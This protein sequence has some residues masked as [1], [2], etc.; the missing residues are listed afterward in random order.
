M[1][2]EEAWR[3]HLYLQTRLKE[4]NGRIRLLTV[5]P[6][7]YAQSRPE[8]P[9]DTVH[10]FL[11]L[12]ELKEHPA[13]TVVSHRW[14]ATDAIDDTK[15]VLVNGAR[16]PVSTG[17]FDV[18]YHV[19]K[20]TEPVVVWIDALCI[21]H[22]DEHE[23]E[24]SVQI[25]QLAQIYAAAEKTLI[26]LGTTADRSDEAMKA[27]RRLSEEQLT[28][29]AYVANWTPQLAHQLAEKILPA[30][31]VSP[32]PTAPTP[33]SKEPVELQKELESLRAPLK[34]LMERDYWT[35]LWSLVELCLSHRGIV[36]CGSH[37]L[38]LDHF[39]SAARALDHIINHFTYSRWLAA[40][41]EPAENTAGP[42]SP[43]LSGQEISNLSQSPALRILGRRAEHRRETGSWIKTTETP[44]FALLNRY[45]YY[46]AGDDRKKEKNKE[47][48]K[49]KQQQQLALRVRDA[50]DRVYALSCLATDTKDL[51]IAVDYSKGVDQ[52]N[53]EASA[54]FLH[55]YPRV[56]Q[57][58]QGTTTNLA[59]AA[60]DDTFTTASWAIDW[61]N[62][63]VPPSDMGAAEQ[64]PFNACGPADIRYYRA[65]V[66]LGMPGRIALKTAVVDE[67]EEVGARYDE[68][69]VDGDGEGDDAKAQERQR[70]SQ[71][72]YLAEIKRF[73]EES[74]ASI[75]SPYFAEQAAVALAKIPVGDVE[76]SEASHALARASSAT[77]ERYR[78]MLEVLFPPAEASEVDE[79]VQANASSSS[80]ETGS[81][82][83]KPASGTIPYM[84]AM[85]R[86]AGR[87]PFRTRK[88]YVGVGPPDLAVADIV[89]IPYGAP[90]PFA[91]R[92]GKGSSGGD[93]DT[94]TRDNHRLV[95]EVY[96]FGI[97]DGEFMSVHRQESVL[98]VV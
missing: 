12:A 65:T 1:S 20:Q 42:R 49:K 11:R 5:Q 63:R 69:D 13:F 85:S 26:W 96:V 84:A 54:A 28:L 98:Y 88:G 14:Q 40:A 50:R 75:S 77:V 33:G 21:N 67:V 92:K 19:Q 87:R 47:K 32:G 74:T 24:K 95:G 44:L 37:G 72:T 52:V 59:A 30:R 68:F 56:L 10:C 23:T 91:F 34:A 4:R 70:D 80:T 71:R 31:F 55:K 79:E 3:K 35:D 46:A 93:N 8:A 16:V 6:R 27:L 36:V 73:W 38:V 86:M 60:T 43:V 78:R 53:A 82:P 94:D 66:D 89:A 90:V 39:H 57:L 7:Q 22:A 29:S 9:P 62:V 2:D 48:E 61:K 25:A 64:R 17:L 76:V 97:M 58:A 81:Q 45:F 18:L 41:T 15:S 51:G 83:G